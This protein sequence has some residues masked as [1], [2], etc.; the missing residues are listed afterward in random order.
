MATDSSIYI[1]GTLKNAAGTALASATVKAVR[2]QSAAV[3]ASLVD[4][5]QTTDAEFSATTNSSGFFTITVT[6]ALA[7]TCPLTYRLNL[8]DKRYAIIN[9]GV[10]DAGRTFDVGTLLCES[11]GILSDIN[12]TPLVQKN[13][14]ENAAVVGTSPVATVTGYVTV[15]GPLR[16]LNLTLASCP[17]TLV[18]N[19]TS[20]GGG[21]TKIWDFEEGLILPIGGS[22][23]L[24][25]ANALDKSFV[26]SL[27]TAAADTGGS[28]TSTEAD[29]APS[30]AST[31]SSGVGTCKMKTTVSVPVP[32]T[33]MD[34]T[35]TAID[36]YL[37]AAL[38]ANATGAESLTYSGTITYTYIHLGDN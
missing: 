17:V 29:F 1:T 2:L 30:T 33:P 31:T 34:G 3:A 22:T 14:R 15:N 10:N 19:G 5:T 35:A 7:P 32:G 26:A 6:H 18:K 28:L 20:T 9:V 11:V 23:D 27:G 24:T 25:V 13:M 21:G 36:M 38:N 4:S 16:T 37:N 12:I 8:P